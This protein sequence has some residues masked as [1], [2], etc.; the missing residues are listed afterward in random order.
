[1]QKIQFFQYLVYCLV[2]DGR[3]LLKPMYRPVK[4]TDRISIIHLH[5]FWNFDK[6]VAFD[7]TFQICFLYIICRTFNFFLQL[8]ARNKRKVVNLTTGALSSSTIPTLSNPQATNCAFKNFFSSAVSF[9]LRT[10][11]VLKTF[12]P[13][14]FRII[15]HILFQIKALISFRMASSYFPLLFIFSSSTSDSKVAKFSRH[16]SSSMNVITLSSFSTGIAIA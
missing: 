16:T 1:M 7:V 12:T 9:S 10:H 3:C 4:L 13:S 11:L 14:S 6:Y 15:Y 5:I 8:T 2:P